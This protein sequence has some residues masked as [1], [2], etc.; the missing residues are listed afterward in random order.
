VPDAERYR[1]TLRLVKIWAKRRGIYS[2]VLGFYGGI[3]WAIL[4]ARVCQ[5]YPYYTSAA[6]VKRFFRVYDRWNWKNPVVIC[7]IREQSNVAGL[8]AFKIWNPKQYPQDRMHLMPIIT[9]AFPSMNSTHNVTETTKRIILDEFSRACKVVEQVEQSSAEWRDVYR[10]LPFFSM[11]KYYLHIEVLGKNHSVFIRWLGWVE[12]KLRHLV[13]H[14][15]RIPSVQVRPWPNHIEFKDPDWPHATAAFMGLTVAKRTSPGQQGNTVDLRQPVTQFVEIINSWQDRGD[16]ADQVDMRVRHVA[17]RDLPDYVP[18]DGPKPRRSS[19]KPAASAQEAPAAAAD[20]AVA[21]PQAGATTSAAGPEHE[22][23][24]A[25]RQRTA[26][27][28]STIPAAA[29]ASAPPTAVAAVAASPLPT[30]VSSEAAPSAAAAFAGGSG[31]GVAA[32]SAA[33]ATPEATPALA[34]A[35]PAP[36]AVAMSAPPPPASAA[37]ASPAAAAP[38]VPAK[39]K[40]GKITVKLAQ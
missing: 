37:S 36:A 30:R 40:L 10:A 38:V 20:S 31:P 25:K 24:E 28:D 1:D 9:P 32:P 33:A 39:R 27:H 4:V 17:R 19:R 21:T 8:M 5:L 35:A 14:L 15:E 7:P 13:R 34:A 3:T 18:E 22:E 12:S 23:S 2:N 6:L 16:L 26:V 29:S 11:H